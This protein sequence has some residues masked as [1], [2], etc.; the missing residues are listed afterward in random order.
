MY[1]HSTSTTYGVLNTTLQIQVHF[2]F[3][4]NDKVNTEWQNTAKVDKY[5]QN[6][7]TTVVFE[8]VSQNAKNLFDRK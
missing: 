2:F 4:Y 3:N 6:T 8:N 5:R 1:P 7:M